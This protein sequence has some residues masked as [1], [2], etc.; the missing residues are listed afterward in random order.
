MSCLLL[1]FWLTLLLSCGSDVLLLVNQGQLTLR[2]TVNS[3]NLILVIGGAAETVEVVV[4]RTGE[5]G[6]V[7]L[8]MTGVP[9]GVSTQIQHPGLLNTGR[10]RFEA[11]GRSA[12]QSDVRVTISASDGTFF[13]STEITLQVVPP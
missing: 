2:I 4:A 9:D 7:N 11:T 12:A 3:E 5:T 1:V 13:H 8:T 10:I 6:P